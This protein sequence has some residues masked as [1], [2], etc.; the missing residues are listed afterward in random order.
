MNVRIRTILAF[1][2]ILISPVSNAAA[3]VQPQVDGSYITKMAVTLGS[4]PATAVSESEAVIAALQRQQSARSSLL[5]GEAY[6]V[7]ANGL[8]RLGRSQEASSVLD[9]AREIGRTA[10]NGQR[11]RSYVALL[12]GTI[13]RGSGNFGSA[14]QLFRAAQEGFI[15]AGDDRGHALALQ[16]LGTL[17]V[18]VGDSENAMRY[19][20]LARE[21]YGGDAMFRLSLN[22]NIGV[23]LQNGQRHGEAIAFF[24]S[25]LAIA[26]QQR[27]AA[28]QNQ[29]RIN[30]AVSQVQLGDFVSAERNLRPILPSAD[31]LGAVQRAKLLRVLARVQLQQGHRTA[32]RSLI[33]RALEGADPSTSGSAYRN[34]HFDA[35]QIYKSLGLSELAL[36]QIEA[37]RRID[38]DDAEVTASNRAAVI[39][40]Q[41][42]FAA[43]NARIARLKSEQLRRDAEYQRNVALITIFAGLIALVLLLALLVMAIRSRNRAR[44]DSAELAVVNQRLERALAAKTEFL[45]STSHE[46]RTP[47]NGILGMTQIMLADPA[48]PE[49]LRGQV[50][51]VHDAGTTMRTLVD[52]I[53]D[54]AKI[55]HG[56][57]VISPMP[58]DVGALAA[59]VTRLFEAQSRMRGVALRLDVGDLP[60]GRLL[61]DPDR[62]TQILFNLVG[63]ALKFTAEGAVTVRLAKDDSGEGDSRFVVS[64]RDQGIGIAPEWHEAIFDMFRQVDGTRTRQHGGTGLGLAICRQ[65]ARAMGGDIAVRSAAGEGAT[66]EVVLPWVPVDDKVE[67]GG[68]PYASS[69]AAVGSDNVP[70]IPVVARDPLRAAY[71]AA[72]VRHA[73]SA[74]TVIDAP[75]QIAILAQQ[76]GGICVVDGQAVAHF[77]AACKTLD[78][79]AAHCIVA[80]LAEEE[81]PAMMAPH[82]QSVPFARN[83]VASAVTA[84]I[85]AARQDLPS[86]AAD[87]PTSDATDGKN[88][89]LHQGLAAANGEAGANQSIKRA[90]A[91]SGS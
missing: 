79:L 13:A 49:R 53:L 43:Q 73:G 87:A 1:L 3:Q 36:V 65:L 16:S 8:F 69:A 63:N 11:L 61:V 48:L 58:T 89:C 20:L 82:A 28:Y 84:A 45:A 42:Q 67:G 30:L 22:N 55:E 25:A 26:D 10:P 72:M 6:W 18:D 52:D 29:I 2:A 38:E 34:A 88:S 85:A 75:E 47:L 70:T 23:A 7:K 39:A 81:L 59:R 40:A 27:L 33:E 14:M 83:A 77:A 74:A 68:K 57:F 62:M 21:T 90:R 5:A 76:I 86:E 32:A 24:T 50:D 80:G 31:N 4:D 44:R 19:L 17:Y 66:F 12:S 9:R 15:G 64:V 51:L 56:G 41:F 71:L 35:Y 54:V 91:M 78:G 46:L 37:V 60:D